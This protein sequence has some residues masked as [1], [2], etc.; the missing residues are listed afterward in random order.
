MLKFTEI[1]TN[2]DSVLD[3]VELT[4]Y[5]VGQ[6]LKM[7]LNKDRFLT[8]DEFRKAQEAEIERMKTVL[9]TLMPTAQKAP[10][11]PPKPAP[12]PVQPQGPK[13]GLPQGTPR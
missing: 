2:K 11:Q 3:R 7:D 6:F 5:A 10:A 9:P 12:A 1:D 4:A 8:E 13:P